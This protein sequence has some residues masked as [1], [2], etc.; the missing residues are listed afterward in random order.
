MSG[1][2]PR[3]SKGGR[4]FGFSALTVVGDGEGRV[5]MG[6]GQGQRSPARR[7]KAL[8]DARRNMFRVHMS[9]DTLQYAMVG[10][11]GAVPGCSET[12]GRGHR[13]YF[14]GT[15]RAVFEVAGNPECTDQGD[16]YHQSGECDARH[17]FCIEGYEK[18]RLISRQSVARAWIK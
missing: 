11:H 10:R 2:F 9:G 12:G 5:G 6:R 8:E 17:H 18:A 7:A 3:S 1:V 15:M 14:G 16:W 13:D 4:I